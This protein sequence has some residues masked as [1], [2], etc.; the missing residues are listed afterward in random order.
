MGVL[1]VGLI[2]SHSRGGLLAALAASAAL[3]V[4][5]RWKMRL[6]AELAL[7]LITVSSFLIVAGSW[8]P[9]HRLAM[10]V[11][12]FSDGRWEVWKVS[13]A[14]WLKHPIWGVGFG[15]FPVA[16]A[17]LDFRDRGTFFSRGENEYVD[18]LVEGGLLGL[19]FALMALLTSA[20]LA[21]RALSATSVPSDRAMIVGGLFGGL[22]LVLH[23]LC[24]FSLHIPG[25]AVATVV[26]CA[27]LCRLGL[28]T[29]HTAQVSE[30]SPWRKFGSVLAGLSMSILSLAILTHGYHR[31][32][33]E[34]QLWGSG[35]PAAD[36]YMPTAGRIDRPRPDLERMKMS[37]EQALGDR[38][39]WA[40]GH[41]RL[42][43][44]LL[45][46]Y[47]W[48][49]AEWIGQ[50]VA[51]PKTRATLAD[52]LWL[53]GRVHRNSVGLTIPV[54]EL[55]EHEPVRFY[56]VP[57]ARSFLE[58]RRCCPVLALS[59]V[60]LASLDYLL[61]GGDTTAVY[62]NRALC[63]AGVDR[64]V[65]ELAAVLAV[66]VGDRNLAARCW[67]KSLEVNE[68]TWMH[69]ADAAATVLSPDE[70]LRLVLPP[71]GGRF[72]LWFADR[73]Y[74][75]PDAQESRERF[76]RVALKRLPNDP[77]VTTA[78]RFS[79]QARAHEGLGNRDQARRQ[80]EEALMLDPL[81]GDWRREFAT[82][83]VAWGQIKE[84]HRQV[85]I[86]LQLN[87]EDQGLHQARQ[88]VAETF[89]KGTY[90]PP[91]A[92]TS[93]E[94]MTA[95]QERSAPLRELGRPVPLSSKIPED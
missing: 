34:T 44:T 37:L 17:P 38:P 93:E 72:P 95:S 66:Q 8:S 63:Q 85:I 45:S 6:G 55:L 77:D 78:Q 53:H 29:P 88:V 21:C 23:W 31:A 26:L 43:M 87:P 64:R 74:T 51:D 27:Y 61:Q 73:L 86:G 90:A 62:A 4:I 76:L 67:R 20:R 40:E 13:I 3:F 70:I 91:R 84:A 82:W 41:V 57:A 47:Q 16:V 46:L 14:A 56:L 49:A 11:E 1:V 5:L 30:P 19:G 2:A 69:V 9:F 81:R 92:R 22:A 12:A 18:V 79:L 24:D 71:H 94:R 7:V 60:E 83:L 75:G 54:E 48:T 80:M 39:D 15:S 50:E 35:I 32:R 89:A 28:D 52:P 42:G 10:L 65:I 33:A 58:A 36:A 59:H 25:V 68:K